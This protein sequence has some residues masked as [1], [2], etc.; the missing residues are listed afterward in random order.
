MNEII[1]A[2]KILNSMTDEENEH[3]LI[4][5]NVY[6]EPEEFNEALPSGNKGDTYDDQTLSE[7]YDFASTIEDII[8]SFGVVINISL[9]NNLNSLSE[10]IDFYT[11]DTE[12][13]VKNYLIDLRLSDHKQ[14]T[15]ARRNRL[16]HVKQLT[17]GNFKLESIVINQN[18]R[19]ESYE[20]AIQYLKTFLAKDLFQK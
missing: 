12:G 15:N 13:N 3:E 18:S 11:F 17:A 14:T 1:K 6:V 8:N 16:K 4:T 20:D 2:F 5:I 7:W 19:F 10:Y 9:S